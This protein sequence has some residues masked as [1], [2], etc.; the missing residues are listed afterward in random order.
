VTRQIGDESAR[1]RALR[2]LVPHLPESL[3]PKALEV[4][5]QIGD[6]YSRAQAIQGWAHR[7]TQLSTSHAFWC[8]ILHVLSHLRRRELLPTL[9]QMEAFIASLGGKEALLEMLQAM[10][11]V[12]RQ[13][14]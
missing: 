7:L 9:V 1:A 3:L 14:R 13:W 11:Q 2:A 5:R 8:E 12:C 10:R 6:E 4:T